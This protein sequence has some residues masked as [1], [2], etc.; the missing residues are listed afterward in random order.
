MYVICFL[1]Y[2]CSLT[3][4]SVIFEDCG[5][6][7]DLVTV[8]IDGC[9]HSPPC[10]V[11]LGDKIP[12]NVR[13][14]ADFASLQLDQDVIIKLNF[15]NARTPVTPEP[16]DI[17]L[18]PVQTD[19]LTSF[20]SVMSVPTN[21]ALNQR[22]YLQWRVYNEQ[23]RV[24]LCYSVLVQTQTYIQKMLRQASLL[25]KALTEDKIKKV[26]Q[27]PLGHPL[28]PVGNLPNVTFEFYE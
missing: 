27:H 10:Y 17:L 18:C 19:A 26:V 1:L 23:N 8:N 16:C 14:Y 4:A 22:G 11:T 9:G 13:F 3:R 24:V 5:S 20:T 2:F 7:Y 25:T 15:V 12:V 21:M 28:N 6:E